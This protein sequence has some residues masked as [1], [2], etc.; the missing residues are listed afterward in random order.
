MIGAAALIAMTSII[1]KSLGVEMDGRAALHPLQVSAGRFTFAALTLLV[2]MSVVP[3][4][5]PDFGGANWRLH[6]LRSVCGWSGVTAMFAAVA[7]MPLVDATAISFLSPV[8]TMVL[9]ALMLRET[10]GSRKILATLLALSGAMLI[11]RPGSDAFQ[12]ASLYALLA[13]A[14]MGLEAIFIKRLSGTEPA[15]RIL[16]INNLIGTGIAVLAA[17]LVW[18]T[19]SA[20]QW[21]LLVLL[22]GVMVC[23]QALFI[24]AMKRGDAS[25]VMPVFYFVLVFAALYD[26]A[27]FGVI[28]G[29]FAI[30]GAAMIVLSAIALSTIKQG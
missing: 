15:M 5:R 18:T 29:I 3:R 14:L 28:P 12:T 19:P 6:F 24:Q 27:L 9:A 7:K 1:G 26:L 8:V 4:L 16:V 20:E 21:V 23:G 25:L 17:S 30:A 13:A 2:V 11:L 22:G 10:V